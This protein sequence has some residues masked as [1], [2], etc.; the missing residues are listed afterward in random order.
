MPLER[1]Y[2]HPQ[3]ADGYAQVCIECHKM[4]MKIRRLT[5]PKVQEYD[6]IRYHQSDR[7]LASRKNAKEWNT[8]NPDGYRA[9]Y[10]V[11]NAIRDGKLQKLPCVICGNAKAHAH[12]KD[13][14]RPL[15]VVWM[16]PQC[17]QRMHSAFPE[18]GANVK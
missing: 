10:I 2:R 8:K 5:N 7:K 12:H 9:H 11:H 18:L 15:D 16:C 14:S 17:H 13:Y 4:R 3:M 6:R 1:F